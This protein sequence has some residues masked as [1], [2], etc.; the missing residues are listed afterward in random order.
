MCFISHMVL[1]IFGCILFLVSPQVDS[2]PSEV[3]DRINPP[4]CAPAP[5]THYRSSQ[6]PLTAHKYMKSPAKPTAAATNMVCTIVNGRN[7]E[8]GHN[9]TPK[10]CFSFEG[11]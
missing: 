6:A 5:F 3:L 4:G 7:F 11:N 1:I 10:M 2:D 8:P 9:F